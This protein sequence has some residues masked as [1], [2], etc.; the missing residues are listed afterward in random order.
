MPAQDSLSRR[1]LPIGLANRIKVTKPVRRDEL[2][3]TDAVELDEGED[4]VRLRREM[5]T[6][7]SVP[8]PA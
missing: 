4:V 6:T 7:F 8:L 1:A 3:T 2:V 5:E